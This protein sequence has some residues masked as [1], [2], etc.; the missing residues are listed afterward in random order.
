MTEEQARAECE[1]LMREHPERE[2]FAWF[3][4]PAPSGDWTVVRVKA[5]ALRVDRERLVLSH[6]P[7]PAR[8]NP[9]LDPPVA[10]KPYWGG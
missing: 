10:P 6:D 7:A 3:A 2:R 5:G 1:R 4:R 9:A 8:P